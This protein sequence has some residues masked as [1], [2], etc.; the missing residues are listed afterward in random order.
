M[1]CENCKIEFNIPFGSN[2]FCSRS[3]A[4]KRI[5]TEQ[6]KQKISLSVLNRMKTK[7]MWGFQKI[8]KPLKNK[9]NC[10]ICNS[11]FY[12]SPSQNRKI[13]CSQQCY[14]NDKG[15]K[16]YKPGSGGY[17]KGSGTGKHGY[18]KGIWCDSTYELAYLIYCLDHN[19]NIKR[20]NEIFNY[21]YE[22]KQLKYHP[23]FIVENNLVEIKG[24]YSQMVDAKINAVLNKN[25]P[26]KVLYKKDL[27]DIFQYIITKYNVRQ[28]EIYT[29][30]DN[31]KPLY[32]YIC[33]CCN[34]LFSTERR[35]KTVD[36]FCSQ[37]CAG[38]Y[39]KKQNARITQWSVS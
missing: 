28:N 3:C 26:I 39:R 5:R 15:H 33:T 18:Y 35:R 13:F 2:R 34:K 12:V 32:E 29:L 36:K 24:Y 10:P 4:N 11:T 21:I 7:G 1:I 25:I 17:R 31:H 16:F 20:N 23:D 14:L 27:K 6:I 8:L 9:K 22:N 38:V 37:Y 30:Y 19:I